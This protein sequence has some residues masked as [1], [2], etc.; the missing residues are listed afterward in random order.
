MGFGAP[1]PE[2]TRDPSACGSAK[3]VRLIQYPWR[4]G[5]GSCPEIPSIQDRLIHRF[6]SPE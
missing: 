6:G 2:A 1:T 4:E 5:E 3:F